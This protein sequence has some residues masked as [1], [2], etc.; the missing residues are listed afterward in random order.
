MNM[1][2]SHL[3]PP[4]LYDHIKLTNSKLW[5]YAQNIVYSNYGHMSILYCQ[6]IDDFKK[7]S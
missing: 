4:D 1:Y 7:E 6:R 5:S 2:E 3:F